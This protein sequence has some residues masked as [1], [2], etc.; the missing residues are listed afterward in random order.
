MT[1][2]LDG[3]ALAKSL[4]SDLAEQIQSMDVQPGLAVVLVGD[5]PASAVYV[6]NKQKMCAKIGAYS[7]LHHLPE[8]TSQD[9]L[10]DLIHSL[11]Q[12]AAI[13]GIL[14]QLP[15]P[16]HLNAE[17]I[18]AAVSPFKDVDGLHTHNAGLLFK[19]L[20]TG[21]VPCTPLGMIHLLEHYKIP[22][23][24][25]QALI[26]GRSNLVGKP[27]AMLLLNRHAT[28]SMAHSRTENLIK[29]TS[30]ADILVVA[31]G[32]PGII[33]GEMVKPGAVILDVGMNRVDGKLCGDVDFDTCAERASYITPVPG[34][35]GPMTVAMLLHNTVEA[36][37][38][39][40]T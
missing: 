15:L 18:L 23:A 27:M 33:T 19:G 30:E 32:Q 26:V 1:Q 29:H 13:H 24:G 7:E 16:Q 2:I 20:N 10:L 5:D 4:R 21:M 17:S 6:R 11:N 38:G 14:V 12:N 9:S 35:V 8:D 39:Y 34:G 31:T 22:V 40:D 3:K 25:K 37:R 36:A 28:V